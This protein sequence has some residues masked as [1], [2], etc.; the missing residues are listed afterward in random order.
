M[1]DAELQTII[2]LTRA[3]QI[4][5]PCDHLMPV[6]PVP[7][8]KR[9]EPKNQIDTTPSMDRPFRAFTPT[10]QQVSSNDYVHLIYITKPTPARPLGLGGM[11]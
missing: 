2:A 4:A 7:R 11:P 3:I 1:P 6:P 8:K 10:G 9:G 5:N